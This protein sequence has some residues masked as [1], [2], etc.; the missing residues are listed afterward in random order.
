M[1]SQTIQLTD[2]R[3]AVE[4][5]REGDVFVVMGTSI[6]CA[7]DVAQWTCGR[8]KRFAFQPLDRK[9]KATVIRVECVE[10]RHGKVSG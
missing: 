8:A 10:V 9:Y 6:Q 4:Q 5:A 3:E 7:R 1:G 2:L